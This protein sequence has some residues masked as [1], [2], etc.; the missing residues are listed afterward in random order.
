MKGRSLLLASVLTILPGAGPVTTAQQ[1]ITPPSPVAHPA[2]VTARRHDTSPPLS[3][4][5]I[6][7][8]RPVL[9]K[10]ERRHIPAQAYQNRPM[11]LEPDPVRQDVAS[12]S[13]ALPTPPP[14]VGFEGLNSDDNA[15]R[16]G[17]RPV[18]PDTQGDVSQD[19]YV[20]MINLVFAVYDKAGNKIYGPE[21]N[22]ILW[23][24][25]GGPCETHNDGDP[26]VLFD[27]LAN[28]WLFSQIAIDSDP[29]SPD[30]GG[31]QCF[32]ISTTSDPRG[33]YY[34]YDFILAPGINDYPKLGVWP[35]GYYLTA[36][37]FNMQGTQF[38]GAMAVVLD[39]NAMLAGASV[40]NGVKFLLD[41]TFCGILACAFSLQ[42]SH[43]AG[44][45]PPAGAPNT[46]VMAFDVETWG[47]IFDTNDG[48]RIWNFSTNWNNPLSSTFTEQAQVNAP[49]FDAELCGYGP[50]VPQPA[51]GELLSPTSQF[52]MYRAQYRNFGTHQTMVLNHTVD[53]GNNV[54]GIRWTELRRTTGSPWSLYQTGTF[55]PADGVH[56]WMG[57]IAMDKVGN[58]ALGYSASGTSTFPGIRYNSRTASDPP[59]TLPGGEVL[60]IA[61]S[62][63][64]VNSVNRWGDYSTM[65]VD[66]DGCTFWY[67]QEYQADDFDL[68]QTRDFKTRIGS[69]KLDNCSTAAPVRDLA[70]TQ[71]VAPVSVNQGQQVVVGVTLA[72]VGNTNV[73]DTIHVSLGESPD[74]SIFPDQSIN[75]LAAGASQLFNFVWQTSASTTIGPHTLTASHNIGD[76]NG[77]NNSKTG[78]ITVNSPPP[79]PVNVTVT[80]ISPNSMR[81]GTTLNNVV[82][83]GT[84]FVGGAVVTFE[85]G[86]GQAPTMT[87]TSVTSTQIQGSITT[88]TGG[89]RRN[90]VWNV[91][92]TNTDGTTG[93]LNGGFTVTP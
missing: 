83:T 29:A 63:V 58:I 53:A 73:T 21:P 14:G 56:R 44:P 68:S 25:M 24:G 67:T 52:T 41:G 35:D 50:C 7:G 62:D 88:K 43:L 81:A 37:E 65:S 78:G 82:I 86:T 31:H 38:L 8:P 9:N 23:S 60:M 66:P 3:A 87:V 18:P 91:R 69:F 48:Y 36:N 59:G 10:V 40:I 75:G 54:A 89:P 74:G 90:R 2:T 33:P 71:V 15:A 32:A 76:D 92:V 47:G 79:P 64:Q 42:P 16:I 55:A 49:A 85:G 17:G 28:R 12:Q 39:R 4:M 6:N 61:G 57:S 27:H 72:N 51:P 20:Q 77:A 11:R 1:I 46:F 93:D 45:T 13:S 26:I 70:I 84:G 22:N 19:Y 80:S 30:V 5:R 34:R